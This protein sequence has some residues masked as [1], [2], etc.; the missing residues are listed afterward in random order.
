MSPVAVSEPGICRSSRL[1]YSTSDICS[2][3]ATCRMPGQLPGRLYLLGCVDILFPSSILASDIGTRICTYTVEEMLPPVEKEGLG[4]ENWLPNPGQLIA[5]SLFSQVKCAISHSRN[6][7]GLSSAPLR[8][9]FH[10]PLATGRPP[11]PL[12]QLLCVHYIIASALILRCMAH[13]PAASR[14][15]HACS[16]CPVASIAA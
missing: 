1:F 13:R 14:T 12:P 8:F 2:C 15:A 11:K 5:S 6:T 7:D 16:P 9:D 4:R 3:S 10:P